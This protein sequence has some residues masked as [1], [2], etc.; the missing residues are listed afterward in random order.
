MAFFPAT[1]TDGQQANVGNIVYQWSA[2]T[3]AWNRIGSTINS[4]LVDGPILAI[5]G[6][7]LCSGTG[8]SQF[9][10]ELNVLGNLLVAGNVT[11]ARMNTGN[12]SAGNVTATTVVSLGAI[13][14]GSINTSGA[15]TATGQI[16][17]NSTLSSTQ[18]ITAPLINS[19]GALIVADDINGGGNVTVPGNVTAQNLLS[20]NSVTSLNAISAA[21]NVT[22][23]NIISLGGVSATGNVSGNYILGNGS[24]LTGVVTGGG[25]AGNRANVTINTGTIANAATFTGNV[26]MAKGYAVY[27]IATTNAAW[28]RLYSNA[29]TQSEDSGRSQNN[30]PQPGSGVMVEAITNGANV[31]LISPSALGWND[32]TPPSNAIP[33]SVTNLSGGSA[34]IGVTFT[35]L[36]I[37]I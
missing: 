27:K 30:D 12:I 33:I 16:L 2:A 31:V 14:G 28:V 25:G 29:T 13:T 21:G 17:T 4:F 23:G 18:Q 7:I 10:A 5:S 1:P 24:L 9:N 20:T 3:G 15:I 22:G 34:D 37:E 35:Y 19:T 26:V 11:S 36:G 32:S 8:V 6:N